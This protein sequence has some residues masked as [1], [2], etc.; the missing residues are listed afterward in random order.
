MAKNVKMSEATFVAA[1]AGFA[2]L[3]AKS[4]EQ[5]GKY[6]AQMV[7]A[8]QDMIGKAKDPQDQFFARVAADFA[9]EVQEI[10]NLAKD[11]AE[12]KLSFMEIDT[13]HKGQIEDRAA[14]KITARS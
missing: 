9:A 6:K 14:A 13:E 12:V 2:S 1:E 4:T 8:T 7:N 10:Q 11:I 5:L 3:H